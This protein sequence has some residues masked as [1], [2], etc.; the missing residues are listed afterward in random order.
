VK[1]GPLGS[2]K[3]VLESRPLKIKIK[4]KKLAKYIVLPASLLSRLKSVIGEI[5][6]EEE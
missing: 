4:N 6:L 2:E 5:S 3:Q 1:I